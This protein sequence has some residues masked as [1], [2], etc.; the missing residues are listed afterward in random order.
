MINY[1]RVRTQLCFL[2]ITTINPTFAKIN[3]HMIEIDKIN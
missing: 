3:Q 2:Q 1:P